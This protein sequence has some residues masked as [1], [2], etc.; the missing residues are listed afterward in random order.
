MQRL[1]QREEPANHERWLVSYAD[2]ITLMFAFFVVMYAS[3]Q[4]DKERAKLLSEA[5]D[6][7]LSQGRIPPKIS[8]MM[9][10]N[11]GA[12]RPPAPAALP[13]PQKMKKLEPSLDALR[14]ALR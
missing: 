1:R 7:A 5:V 6:R 10:R 11:T 9:H 14:N 3:S 12:P 8:E 13:A 2:F 4:A